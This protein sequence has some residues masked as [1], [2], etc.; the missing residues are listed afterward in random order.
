MS[1]PSDLPP[2][3]RA[4]LEAA[5]IEAEEDAEL[6]RRL[7]KANGQA[8]I[9]IVGHLHAIA[10]LNDR[11]SMS[12]SAPDKLSWTWRGRVRGLERL[13]YAIPDYGRLVARCME[14]TGRT[15]SATWVATQIGTLAERL[16]ITATE[17]AWMRLEDAL[18]ALRGAT[19]PSPENPTNETNDRDV[20]LGRLKACF[21]KEGNPY[22]VWDGRPCAPCPPVC[23]HFVARLIKAHG[24][25]VSFA[26]WVRENPTFEGERSDRM[27][28]R[29]PPEVRQVIDAPGK[30]APMRLI[31]QS[32]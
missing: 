19:A 18:P 21:P 30:G 11:I 5:E 10:S 6:I 25:P 28:P 13:L 1:G 12:T 24:E 14:E 7:E 4:Q 8:L 27:L 32:C 29:L 3:L 23:V 17:A 9:Q 31:V 26:A 20:S 16:D 15:P 22:F 2:W